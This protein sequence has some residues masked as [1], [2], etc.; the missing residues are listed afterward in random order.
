MS[1]E[2]VTG[3]TQ[4]GMKKRSVTLKSYPC[5]AV[6]LEVTTTELPVIV[7]AVVPEPER[8]LAAA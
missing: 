7:Q 6:V 2:F 1:A 4:E 3:R 5:G 8:E